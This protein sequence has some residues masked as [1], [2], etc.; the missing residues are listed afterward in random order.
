MSF[1][2]SKLNVVQKKAVELTEGPIMILAGAG[3]GK[4]RTLVT[5]IAYLLNEKRTSPHQLLALTFSNKA[6]REMRERVSLD[7][8]CDI[9][10]LQITT[11]HSFCAKVLRSEATYLGLSRS[12]T[13]YDDSESKAIVKLLLDR[14]GISP[15]EVNPYDI[16][17][18]IDHYKNNGYY[19][20]RASENAPKSVDE[21]Y[22][23][24]EEYES[25]LARAN[26]I[27]FGGLI[28][29]V[30]QLFEKFPEVSNR[31][32]E[33]FKYIL[34]DEYQDTNRAQFELV[35]LLCGK[36]KN[37]CVVGDEDQ[38][39]YSWRGADI[40]NILDFEK[41]FPDVMI[42]KLEQNY[43]SSK[44]IIEAASAVIEKNTMR[45]GKQMWTE[46]PDGDAIIIVEC[47]N[48]K[49]EA[50]YIAKSILKYKREEIEA[51]E[52]AVFYRSNAQAR[53]I[54]DA[55][56]KHRI[57]YRV[58]GG[59]RFY[60]RK[61]IK[62][63][64]AYLRLVI[65]D[66]DSLALS[67]IIN[68][69]ARGIGA[70][71]LRKL[72]MEAINKNTSLWDVIANVVDYSEEFAHIKLSAK[73]KSALSEFVHL[74]TEVRILNQ[75]KV[76]P[77]LIYD[78][79]LHESGYYAFLKSHKDIETLARLENLDELFNAITQFE[80]ANPL[81]DL[82][83]FLETITLDTASD[84]E[85]DPHEDQG[86]VSLMTVHGAKGL[87]FSHTFLIGAEENIFPS[88]RSIESGPM[89]LE[90]ERRLFYV[91]MTRAMEKLTIT[92]AQGRMLFGQ[93]KFNGPSRFIDEIP[94]RYYSWERLKSFD[95]HPQFKTEAHQHEHSQE[96]HYDDEVIYQV[97][98]TFH[99]AK[100]PKGSLIIHSLYGKG[101]VLSTEGNG[102]EEK[103]LIKFHDG[104]QKKFMVKYA[105]IHLA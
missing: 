16:L 31:Y 22:E 27:D 15:K 20:G 65:N 74:V 95:Q 4:T 54:E 17:H 1:D 60:E 67:R 49:D 61:E 19:V 104:Q 7:V 53:L 90:E 9:G 48:D 5:R 73:I 99:L 45:K 81:L 36:R 34:V 11:F 98:E 58:I 14:R 86:E 83:G 101:L 35:T 77:S 63:V 55:F 38:S 103:V 41:S 76:K 23:Y 46:N 78:K 70:T 68:I 105:P 29:A 69:P 42:L 100:Y 79:V 85:K 28:T 26:A 44:T 3:S 52:M 12:F 91:A 6:A 92:F 66:K 13:I 59:V 18:Y 93:L 84:E 40:R 21:F 80:E 33:R 71:T 64:L 47:F 62:D 50:E 10:S 2:L 30:I 39:I 88:F 37:I 56:R 24:F 89:G 97:R 8:E 51:K 43:R 75:N 57:N 94:K 87:E 72:E 102:A 25:E 96:T 82:S 32:S